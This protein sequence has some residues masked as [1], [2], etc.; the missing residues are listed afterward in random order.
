M[1]CILEIFFIL[2]I[3]TGYS[4]EK[5]I[6]KDIVKGKQ[7]DNNIAYLHFYPGID[8]IKE[9]N[10]IICDN[11]IIEFIGVKKILLKKYEYASEFNNRDEAIY[12]AISFET[13]LSMQIS[14]VN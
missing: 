3:S 7:G 5:I 4:T 8:A 13:E 14:S 1:N 2:H 12:A 11:I 6:I 10:V 9:N